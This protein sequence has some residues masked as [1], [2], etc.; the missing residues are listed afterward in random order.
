MTSS[1]PRVSKYPKFKNK[2]T[3]RTWIMKICVQ[4]IFWALNRVK[5]MK[6]WNFQYFD[7]QHDIVK[8]PSR[9]NTPKLKIKGTKKAWIIQF[10]TMG[11]FWERNRL[12]IVKVWIFKHFSSDD[13]DLSS[14]L[15]I[16][17]Y[18]L[19]HK[20]RVQDAYQIMQLEF[21]DNVNT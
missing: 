11:N 1:I 20:D 8:Y 13:K 15:E 4:G 3:K 16:W 19:S 6:L 9:Q 18:Q 21:R 14:T 2:G 12:K 17:Y 5:M 7:P 10:C